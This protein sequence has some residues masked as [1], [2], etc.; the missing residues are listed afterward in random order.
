MRR[1]VVANPDNMVAIA[2][3]ASG[4]KPVLDPTEFDSVDPAAGLNMRAST[5]NVEL[6]MLRNQFPFV[7]VLPTPI[8][9]TLILAA[10]VPALIQIPD[11]AQMVKIT[12][13]GDYYCNFDGNA[14]IPAAGQGDN[15]YSIYRPENEWWYI[16]NKQQLAF[17]SATVNRVVQAMFLIFNFADE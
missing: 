12:G 11:M 5:P 15:N 7:Q 10:G 1:K 3:D 17:V 14:A 9:R 6:M 16:A 2:V 13:D 4:T 8:V